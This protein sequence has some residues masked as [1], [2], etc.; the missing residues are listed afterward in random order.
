ME[1]K[2]I[3]DFEEQ[4]NNSFIKDLLYK[5]AKDLEY[6][7]VEKWQEEQIEILKILVKYETNIFK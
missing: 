3:E 1:D 5:I 2:Q 6:L 7:D 4:S